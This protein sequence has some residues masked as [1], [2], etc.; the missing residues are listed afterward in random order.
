MVNQ[1]GG[2]DLASKAQ[3]LAYYEQVLA[4]L[5]ATG[6]WHSITLHSHPLGRQKLAA[7]NPFHQ[8]DLA[9]TERL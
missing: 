1:G 6:R 9:P 3:I 4:D 5:L 2:C 7:L 8:G